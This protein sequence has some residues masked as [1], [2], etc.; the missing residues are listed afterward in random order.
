MNKMIALLVA[1]SFGLA[2]VAS[3]Q[4]TTTPTAGEPEL[5]TQEAL[6]AGTSLTAGAVAGGV[7]ALLLLAALIGDDDDATTTTTTTT[8]P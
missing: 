4:S 7:A 5:V 6:V 1:G 8:S 3:A 2:T